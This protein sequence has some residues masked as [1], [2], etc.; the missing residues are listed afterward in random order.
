MNKVNIRIP[1]MTDFAVKESYKTLRANLMWSVD[2]KVFGFTSS[3]PGEG[4]STATLNTALSIAEQEKKVLFIDSDLRK[5]VIHK[6]LNMH[7]HT[8]GLSEYLAGKKELDE[9]ICS[10]NVDYFDIIFSGDYPPNPAELLGRSRL[11]N[12]IQAC[13]NDYDYIIIDTPPIGS[14]IDA[15]LISKCCDGIVVVI[16]AGKTDAK[17]VK[18]SIQKLEQ[19]ECP[20]AGT[21]LNKVSKRTDNAYSKYYGYYYSDKKK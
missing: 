12:L 17:L 16:E 1:K 20:I 14:V 3:I 7:Y 13:R 4:K 2:R 9:I 15:A 11:D 6:R 18:R 5:S 19:L 8:V 21:V 10:T